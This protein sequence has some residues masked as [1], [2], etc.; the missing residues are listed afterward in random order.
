VSA[1]RLA[2]LLA[3]AALCAAAGA[4]AGA[5][6]D[7]A[8][9][10][11]FS[12]AAVNVLVMPYRNEAGAFDA[13]AAGARLAA[14]VQQEALFAML[15]YGSVGATELTGDDPRCDVRA[16]IERVTRASNHGL[17]PG[18]GLAIIWGRIYEEKSQIY[19]Q[20][21]IRFL[22]GGEPETLTAELPAD[23]GAPLRLAARLPAQAAAM[24]PRRL[25]RQDLA[26]IEKRSA[27][28]LV[29][30][31]RPSESAPGTPLA[32][33]PLEPLSYGVVGA[34]G[35]WMQIRS[36]VT[37]QSGWVLARSGDNE[38]ALRRFLPELAYL[39]GV[40][41]Y[42]RLRTLKA[43]P[44]AGNPRRIYNWM[45][46][47]FAGYERAVGRDAAPEAIGLARAMMGFALW[48]E[49]RLEGSRAQAAAHFREALQ[50][51]PASPHARVLAAVTGPALAESA[52][53]DKASLAS[54]NQGL[55]GAVAI[56]P[57]NAPALANLQS[58]YELAGRDPEVSP[59]AP[60][61]I[62]KRL[63][64]VKAAPR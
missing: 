25:T 51:M 27:G 40:V 20:S 33:S 49:P 63:G 52:R 43:Q 61:E 56:D 41:G 58:L 11:V 30:R 39:D 64:A 13:K 3:C 50:L 19:L 22:R 23:G 47:A 57:R 59:Y 10:R 8:E 60:E 44:Y 36:F 14:L 46:Q 45:Q 21:Y 38:W 48:T 2:R 34:Q 29:L 5:R 12:D 35:D 9:A 62:Q 55:L 4:Q 16:A 1:P 26:Q 24:V 32:S 54:I 53:A 28:T 6:L 15:K 17:R 31:D 18:H 37:G 7:C 42:L